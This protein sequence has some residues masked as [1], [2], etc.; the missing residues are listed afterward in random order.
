M[1][2]GTGQARWQS[3]WLQSAQ[4]RGPLALLLWPLSMAYR[5]VMAF[6]RKLYSVGMFASHKPEVPVIVVG[7]VVVGGAGKT[8]TTLALVAHLQAQGWRPGVI[9]RGH[10]RQ[11]EDLVHVGMDT[12]ARDAGDEPLFIRQRTGVPVCVA[13]VRLEA[14]RGLLA[15]HPDVDIL[16]CDDGMQHLALGRDL[17]VAVFDDRGVGNGWLLP[18]GL[19]REPWP[20]APAAP[21]R[22]DMVLR[23]TRAGVAACTLPEVPDL[24]EFNALRQLAS[25]ATGPAGEQRTLAQLK[26]EPLTAVAG[27]ARPEVFFEMLRERGLTLARCVALPDHA[28]ATDYAELLDTAGHPLICTEKDAVKLFPLVASGV[29]VQTWAVALELVPEPAFF[30]A[31]DARLARL[32]SRHGHQTA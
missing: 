18:A 7:N 17:T 11:S 8:P 13:R 25:F 19:L 24:P 20:L 4:R 3:A 1:S 12:P 15:I 29:S 22:P 31:V 16:I 30:S 2:Q 26:G 14:A 23:Q 6:R 10:G 21:G 27:I 9:S 28:D 5:A 32:S